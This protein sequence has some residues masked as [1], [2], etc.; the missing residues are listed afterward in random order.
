MTP[1]EILFDAIFV[2][3]VNERPTAQV[4]T[5]LG[6]F[7]LAKVPASGAGA[8]DFAARSDLETLGDR[9]L[10]FDA[11]GTTHN[12]IPVKKGRAV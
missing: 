10:R 12:S 9:F 1:R 2:R 11:F 8:Q 4:A 7:G 5:A 3:F 6:A